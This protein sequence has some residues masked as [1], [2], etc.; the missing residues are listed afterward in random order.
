MDICEY[1]LRLIGSDLKTLRA[2]DF[3]E[4]TLGLKHVCLFTVAR[5]RVA[6]HYSPG[7][8]ISGYVSEVG[9]T[10]DEAYE[11]WPN[12]YCFAGVP[13]A[14]DFDQL[15]EIIDQFPKNNDDMVRF[16]GATL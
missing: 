8:G 11:S 9:Q 2:A 15:D 14:E 7:D 4:L 13:E 16:I 3:R 5:R 12:I 1:V 10:G 6:V